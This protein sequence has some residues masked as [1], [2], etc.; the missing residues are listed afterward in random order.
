MKYKLTVVS[1]TENPKYA[2]EL[3]AANSRR[4]Y[5]QYG[6]EGVSF[7]HQF[8]ENRTLEVELT[9]QEYKAVRKAVIEVMD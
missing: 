4:Q 1:L 9:E 7:P 5:P 2:E 8:I 6:G 3:E